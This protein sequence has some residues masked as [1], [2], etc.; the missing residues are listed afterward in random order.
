[1]AVLDELSDRLDPRG[2]RE[3]LQFRELALRVDSLRE[4]GDDEPTLGVGSGRGIR[5]P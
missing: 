4:H 5:L 2:A 3:L 1:V